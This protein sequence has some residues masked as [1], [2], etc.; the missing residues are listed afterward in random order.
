MSTSDNR[1]DGKSMTDRPIG[2]NMY[3][4]F[5]IRQEVGGMRHLTMPVLAV[6]KVVAHRGLHCLLSENPHRDL[7]FKHWFTQDLHGLLEA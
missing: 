4:N 7:V 6:R 2:I 3:T 1:T 5:H